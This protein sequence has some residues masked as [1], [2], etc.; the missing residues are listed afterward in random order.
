MERTYREPTTKIPAVAILR[1]VG[2][3]NFQ[4]ARMGK[5]R[6]PASERELAELVIVEARKVIRHRSSVASFQKA[7]IGVHW[8][9][10]TTYRTMKRPMSQIMLSNQ[11]ILKNRQRQL[12]IQ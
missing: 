10:I 9:R 5:I 3:F 2:I 7:L 11:P 8:V 1:L 6:I 12:N 4:T